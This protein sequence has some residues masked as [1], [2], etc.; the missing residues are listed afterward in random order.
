MTLAAKEDA[1]IGLEAVYN[2]TGEV[3][4]MEYGKSIIDINKLKHYFLKS[5][6]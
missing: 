4:Q 2:H 6:V 1:S 5:L 3:F